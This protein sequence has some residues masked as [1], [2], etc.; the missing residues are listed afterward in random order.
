MSNNESDNKE[1]NDPNIQYNDARILE[2]IDDAKGLFSG[3][4][5]PFQRSGVAF[6]M[7]GSPA[8]I[9]SDEMGLGKTIQSIYYMLADPSKGPTLVLCPKSLCLQWRSQIEQFAPSLARRTRVCLKKEW[10]KMNVDALQVLQNAVFITN[11]ESLYG[12]EV[13]SS[14]RWARLICDEAH[15]LKNRGS[16]I[17]QVVCSLERDD[18]VMLTGTPVTNRRQDLV[19]LLQ[20]C[21][22]DTIQVPVE[23]LRE[24][25]VLRRTQEVVQGSMESI[26]FETVYVD[27]T[28]DEKDTYNAL[29][30][31]GQHADQEEKLRIL[32][33]A[34]QMLL[35]GVERCCRTSLPVLKDIEGIVCQSCRSS[36]AH[37][38]C[39]GGC[40]VCQTCH[41][42]SNPHQGVMCHMCH[43]RLEATSRSQLSLVPCVKSKMR[44]T[45]TLIESCQ[46]RQCKTVVFCQFREEIKYLYKVAKD[47][48]YK[49]GI[50]DGKTPHATRQRVVDDFH[51]CREPAI[52]FVNNAVGACGLNL[53]CANVVVL[54]CLSWVAATDMQSIARSHRLGQKNKVHVYRVVV[55]GSI[56]EYMLSVQNRKVDVASSV[57]QDEGM[58]EKMGFDAA[59]LEQYSTECFQ[60]IP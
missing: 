42:L 56:E 32:H 44:A 9:V 6:L 26:D 16:K 23:T 8:S 3:E 48:R 39:S 40:H 7:R 18:T 60:S 19:S 29:A 25:Y 15:T 36:P 27:L 38:R 55:R 24:T 52:L 45:A 21:R 2:R 58:R 59:M 47:L 49:C 30:S 46:Q 50:L 28:Q 17:H 11:Y 35:C 22:V 4:L 12:N 34:R 51:E 13:M 5:L 37:V 43:S 1:N 54:N 33:L 31:M 57:L 53:Q 10:T 41:G 14:V 20:A